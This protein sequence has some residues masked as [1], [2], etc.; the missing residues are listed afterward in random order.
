M[1]PEELARQQAEE[2]N[3]TLE[4]ALETKNAAYRDK[5]LA[6]SEHMKDV[7]GLPELI[8]VV[9]SERQITLEYYHTILQHLSKLNKEYKKEYAKLY[10]KFKFEVQQ[11]YTTEQAINSQVSS[12]LSD[13]IYKIE[14]LN[15][16]AKYIGETVKTID[17][18]I[19]GIQNRIRLEEILIGK[20]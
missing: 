19:Y 18:I 2:E 17:D 11:R 3:K 7:R 4:T 5:V 10:N 8:N 12:A 20:A 9:Y 14:L 13:F 16:H 6:L 15:N 1:T